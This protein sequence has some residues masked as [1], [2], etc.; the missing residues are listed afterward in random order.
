MQDIFPSSKLHLSATLLNGVEVGHVPEHGLAALLEGLLQRG[1][2]RV[3]L[4]V[5]SVV[6]V[7]E[8]DRRATGVTA[9]GWPEVR[10]TSVLV[11]GDDGRCRTRVLVGHRSVFIFKV[12]RHAQRHV[13]GHATT[14]HI[15]SKQE[16]LR[17]HHPC[18]YKIH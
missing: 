4:H 3:Q 2:P 13:E 5:G 8:P 1:A 12:I 17:E 16:K 18:Q 6:E 10:S 7:L 14:I 11:V 15:K 9:E